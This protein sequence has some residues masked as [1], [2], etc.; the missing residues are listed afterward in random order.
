MPGILPLE[1]IYYDLGDSSLGKYGAAISSVDQVF[2]HNYNRVSGD[3]F[4]VYYT[5]QVA[6][7]IMPETDSLYSA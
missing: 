1:T 3:N 2:V 5:E 6:S 4:Q 7:F